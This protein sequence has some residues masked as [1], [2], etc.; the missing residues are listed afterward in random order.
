M[1]SGKEKRD[2]L[3]VWGY[4]PETIPGKVP[5]VYNPSHC[6]LETACSY[7]NCGN[8][9]FMN[10]MDDISLL[11]ED[12][13]R[14]IAHLDSVI[15]ALQH[16]NYAESARA[17]SRF[18][19]LHPN[20]KGAI[21]DDFLDDGYRYHGPSAKMAPKELKEIRDALRSENPEL[22]LAVVRYTW[23]DPAELEPFLPWFDI[24][25]LWVWIS[26]ADYWNAE[27]HADVIRYLK[28]YDKP[29]MQGLFLHQYGLDPSSLNPVPPELLETQLKRISAEL[30]N[31]NVSSLCILQSGWFCRES[32]RKQIMLLKEYLDRFY[33]TGTRL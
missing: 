2:N 12:S 15:C 24:L 9:V 32:H 18:S 13:F 30:Q 3:W 1:D 7:L 23:Q 22:K 21:L 6:S 4:V 8:A 11:N 26:T 28:R 14:R 33:G 5:F 20:I 16:G 29:I 10:S 19:L 31:G 27:Y 17:I 25:N